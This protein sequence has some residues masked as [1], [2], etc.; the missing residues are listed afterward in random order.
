V[1]RLRENFTSGSYGEGLETGL[2]SALN[3]HER[4][5]PGYS[6]G[7]SYRLPRQPFTRQSLFKAL[8]SSGFALED[9]HLKDI[10]RLTTLIAVVSLTFTWALMVGQWQHGVKPIRTKSHGRRE[11]SVFRY[12]L[13]F[14]TRALANYYRKPGLLHSAI[15]VLSCT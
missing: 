10:E 14:I 13:D 15:G 11:V 5:N 3:G 2:R 12:G 6:Q 8:K 9:T 4:G 7:Q 1:S